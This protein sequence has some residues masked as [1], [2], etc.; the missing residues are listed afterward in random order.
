MMPFRRFLTLTAAVSAVAASVLLVGRAQEA[1]PPQ[2][3]ILEQE[4]SAP[5]IDRGL[6]EGEPLGE[7]GGL[8]TR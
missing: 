2:P 5:A 1:G 8:C 3:R 6:L 7:P 4:V